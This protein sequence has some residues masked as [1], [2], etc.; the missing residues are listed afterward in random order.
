MTF[1]IA[2]MKIDLTEDAYGLRMAALDS[3]WPL[4]GQSLEETRRIITGNFEMVREM[5]AIASSNAISDEDLNEVSLRV[6]IYY[7]YLYNSWK[8]IYEKEK[9]RD[10]TF[11]EKDFTHPYTYDRVIQ[12]F[13][14]KYPADYADKCAA[15]L[16][17]ASDEV[18]KYESDTHAF[19]TSFR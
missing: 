5:Y 18:L 19:Y 15:L 14:N 6:V 7:F 2:A 10:L 4:P 17:M 1:Y 12:F 11:L 16:A 3:E 8:G 9:N 13:R